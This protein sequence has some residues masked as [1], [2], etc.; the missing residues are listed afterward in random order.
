MKKIIVAPDSFKGSI[1]AP[2]AARAI[3]DGIHEVCP[4]VSYTHLTL[5]TMCQV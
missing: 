1:S 5:P 4:A 2:D 3:A